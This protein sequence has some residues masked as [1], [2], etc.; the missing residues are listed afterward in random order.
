MSN[1]TKLVYGSSQLKLVA[2]LPSAASGLTIF[3]WLKLDSAAGLHNTLELCSAANPDPDSKYSIKSTVGFLK[4]RCAF[5]GDYTLA[6]Y[7]YNTAGWVFVCIKFTNASTVSAGYTF[8][9]GGAIT[10]G[11]VNQS[12]T[13]PALT[14]FNLGASTGGS[15]QYVGIVPSAMSDAALQAQSNSQTAPSGAWAF[16]ALNGGSTADSSGNGRTLTATSVTAS[17]SGAL[18]ANTYRGPPVAFTAKTLP[19]SGDWQALASDGAGLWVAVQTYGTPAYSTD[20]GDTWQFCNSTGIT[21][22]PWCLCAYGLVGGNPLWIIVAGS[23]GGAQDQYLTSTNGINWT[24]RTLPVAATWYTLA[25]GPT[26]GKFILSAFV[27]AASYNTTD[28]ITWNSVPLNEGHHW[29]DTIEVGTRWVIEGT[30]PFEQIS[31]DGG[32]T[33][34]E[35]GWGDDGVAIGHQTWVGIAN[36]GGTWVSPCSETDYAGYATSQDGAA[37]EYQTWPLTG[38]GANAIAASDTKIIAV[39]TSGSTAVQTVDGVNWCN[40]TLPTSGAYSVIKASG[41][42]WVALL[43]GTASAMVAS[44]VGIS[45]APTA[46]LVSVNL[47][48][49]RVLLPPIFRG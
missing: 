12:T 43:P 29:Q 21:S 15:L 35:L 11:V 22:Q 17:I 42:K 30:G 41:G 10:W 27:D 39:P 38:V 24:A 45:Y 8:T 4:L 16:W 1:G 23:T 36:L 33:W 49:K 6:T 48:R 3:G 28:G 7:P 32:A 18:T 5:E 2:A 40:V 31:D 13:A 19:A 46:A 37:W 25:F 44:D 20:G 26:S 14:E 47:Q 34:T 9:P